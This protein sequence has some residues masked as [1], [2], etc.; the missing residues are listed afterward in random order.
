MGVLITIWVDQGHHIKVI[1][2]ENGLMVAS[3]LKEL[4]R[5]IGDNGR[6]DPFSGMYAT[7]NPDCRLPDSAGWRSYFDQEK[8][9]PLVRIS[10]LHVLSLVRVSPGKALEV[11]FDGCFTL[12]LAKAPPS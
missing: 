10:Y 11:A 3:I 4:I 8:T 2:V 12:E 7:V 5:D 9:P 6:A 1:L